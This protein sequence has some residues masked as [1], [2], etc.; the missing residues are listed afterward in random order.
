MVACASPRY[1]AQHG[2]PQT[3]EQLARHRRLAYSQ[4]ESPGD[5]TFI[6]LEGRQSAVEGVA[7]LRSNNVQLLTTAALQGAGVVYGPT[8]VFGDHLRTGALVALLPDFSTSDLGVHAIYPSTRYLPT[9][10]RRLIDQLVT[11]FGD[12][13][14]WDDLLRGTG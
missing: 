10:V 1:L 11:E 7:A 3:P 12:N 9:K 6:D 13:P 8:F 5:W 14:P 4:S 2:T